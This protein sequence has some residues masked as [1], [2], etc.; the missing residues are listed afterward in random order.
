MENIFSM[1]KVREIA[2]KVTNVVMNYTEIEAKVRE[3][4]NDEAW[5]PTGQLMQ[6]LAHATFTYEHFPEVMSMLWKRMLQDNKQHW[7][8]TYKSL[9]LLNYLIRNGSERVVTSSREHIYDLRSL[10]NYSFIDEIGK[11]QGINIRHKVRELIDF[12]Q[13][14]DKLREERK[15]AKK[16]KDKYI[17]MSSDSMGGKFG[18]RWEDRSWNRDYS[19]SQ[20]IDWDDKP[21]NNTT[22]YKDRSYD[23]YDAERDDSDYETNHTSSYSSKYKDTE[24]IGSPTSSEKKVSLNINAVNNKTPTK[25]AKPLK[26]VDLGAATNFGVENKKNSNTETSDFFNE[27]FN[28][29]D[30]EKNNAN[31]SQEFGNFEAA[32]GSETLSK[33]DNFADFNSAFSETSA[34][35]QSTNFIQPPQQINFAQVQNAQTNIFSTPPQPQTF[36][37]NSNLLGSMPELL[38]TA[39]INNQKLS[40]SDL[41]S[42]LSGFSSLNIQQPGGLSMTPNN[43]QTLIMGSS[44]IMDGLGTENN[45]KDQANISEKTTTSDVITLDFATSAVSNDLRRITKIS[46]INDVNSILH[47]VQHLVEFFPGPLTVPKVLGL[48]EGL[49]DWH[50]YSERAYGNILESIIDKFDESF[51]YNKGKIYNTLLKTFVVENHWFFYESFTILVKHL[52]SEDEKRLTSV[53][54]IIE[55]LVKSEGIFSALL[56]VSFK[57][58][59]SSTMKQVD[60]NC[61]W[62]NTVQLL[63]SLPDRVANALNGDF[64]EI[65][66]RE[67]FCSLLILNVIKLIEFIS[68]VKDHNEYKDNVVWEQTTLLLNKVFLTFNN[69]LSSECLKNFVNLLSYWSKGQT[70][71]KQ[72]INEIFANLNRPAIEVIAVMILQNDNCYKILDPG[73][74]KIKD[75]K[76]I[77]FTKI[78]LLNFYLYKDDVMIYNLTTYIKQVSETELFNL[79]LQLV[80]TWSDKSAINHTS[81]EQHLYITKYIVLIVLLLQKSK[82]ESSNRLILRQKFFPGIE[83]H[84]DSAVE[85]IRIIGMATAEMVVEYLNKDIEKDLKLNFDLNKLKSEEPQKLIKALNG[86]RNFKPKPVNISYEG[87]L[88]GMIKAMGIIEKDVVEYIP[89]ERKF[90]TR[91]AMKEPKNE[92]ITES[93]KNKCAILTIIDHTNFDLDSDDDLEPYD[94][95]NDIK[96]TAKNPPTYLRDLRNGLLENAD[97]ETF[98]LSVENCERLII[99]Q[100]PHDDASLGLEILEILV[101][102]TPTFYVENFDSHVFQSCIA[103]ACIYPQLCAERL[104]KLFHTERTSYSLTHRILMLDILRETAKILSNVKPKKDTPIKTEKVQNKQSDI[105]TAEEVIRRRLENKTRRFIRHKYFVYEMVNKFAGVAGYFFYPLLHGFK[106]GHFALSLTY[107]HDNLLLINYLNTL[108]VFMCYAQNCPIAPKMGHELMLLIWNMWFHKDAQI[109]VCI[110]NM[111]A[112]IAINIPPSIL[113]IEFIDQLIEIR[114]RLFDMLLPYREPNTECKILAQY[115]MCLLDNVLKEGSTNVN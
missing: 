110:L 90:R 95:S 106:K 81:V 33:S 60:A 93:I 92:I 75:W 12:I 29:R 83:V 74:F 39:P 26:K 88:R 112:C 52:K 3:A 65:F 100:L 24:S 45:S 30:Q 89:P 42:D 31:N 50:L 8:R 28:P 102:L 53:V 37:N 21:Q 38:P 109:R 1:W 49:I 58:I 51:P 80:T 36:S 18:D 40:D 84:L 97:P 44:N 57:Q 103:I 20:N 76:Y 48:D 64:P 10:E 101:S 96:V 69:S 9:L 62:E 25:V 87:I 47:H 27:D 32:F 61:K 114:L 15:K 63:V 66:E 77:L 105:E 7:R 111:L 13:D 107:D 54:K 19:T 2:D 99:A 46:S 34:T 14:D 91:N 98:A 5:G 17:G 79:L 94:L 71:Y 113:L 41:L 115:V 6:E 4:T 59:Y 68:D 104:C 55:S 78:P 35:N 11:D 67:N 85:D 72:I 82:L 108:S 43:N 56:Y 73:L 22:G 86:I 23:E 70:R 16:N